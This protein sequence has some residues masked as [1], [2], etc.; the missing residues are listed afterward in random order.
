M[1]LF[2]YN[3]Q[4]SKLLSDYG[5]QGLAQETGRML[6]QQRFSRQRSDLN[7]QMVRA[8]PQFT[9]QWAGRLGSN[10]KSGVFGQKLGEFT[11]DFQRRLQDV[12]LAAA[13]QQAG[14]TQ[15]DLNRKIQ[16]EQLLAQLKQQALAFGVKGI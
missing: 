9:G 2:D 8:F 3:T 10:V 16:L 4:K 12:D 13:Q 7:R 11:G 14:W 15:E 1:N 6:G 5:Q